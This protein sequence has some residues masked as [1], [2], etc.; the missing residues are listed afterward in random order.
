MGPAGIT[1]TVGEVEVRFSDDGKKAHTKEFMAVDI[2][3]QTPSTASWK[4][5]QV[6]NVL[7]D[8]EITIWTN[9]EGVPLV[10]IVGWRVSTY[11]EAA[12]AIHEI[13]KL[14]DQRAA[15]E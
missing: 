4:F 12:E 15:A 1:V 2:L 10:G 6:R 5:D 3:G 11:T 8:P 13:L 7:D 9:S 14:A